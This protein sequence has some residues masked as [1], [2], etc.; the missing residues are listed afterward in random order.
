MSSNV[1][2]EAITMDKEGHKIVIHDADEAKL[3]A[4]GK[5]RITIFH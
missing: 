5:K 4:L 3:A 1:A 2:V